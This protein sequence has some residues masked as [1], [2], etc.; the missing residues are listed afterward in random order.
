MRLEK[1]ATD[2]I[3]SWARPAR[4]PGPSAVGAWTATQVAEATV[5]W[6]VHATVASVVS[7]IATVSVE[8]IIAIIST[9]SAGQAHQ[10]N[11]ENKEEERKKS[12]VHCRVKLR[13]KQKQKKTRI[14]SNRMHKDSYSQMVLTRVFI[15]FSSDSKFHL[16]MYKHQ[17]FSHQ[18]DKLA[19][20]KQ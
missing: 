16:V 1:V 8:S 9:H 7:I 19:C 6:T 17:P 5:L 20:S 12:R 3:G 15:V 11:K 4:T 13:L 10:S 2:A 14:E 18:Y